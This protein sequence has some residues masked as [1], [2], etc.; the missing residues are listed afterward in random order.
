MVRAAR[1]SGD[2][3]LHIRVLAAEASAPRLVVQVD[4]TNLLQRVA[5]AR[6][7]TWVWVLTQPPP[8]ASAA[9]AAGPSGGSTN[10]ESVQRFVD[11]G[12]YQRPG[13]RRWL[14]A[15]LTSPGDVSVLPVPQLP[16]LP[17]SGEH[18]TVIEAA[19]P[20][21]VSADARKLVAGSEEDCAELWERIDRYLSFFDADGVEDAAIA[22][23]VW[24]CAAML[25][26]WLARHEDEIRGSS[27]LELGAGTGVCGLYAAAL[28][29]SRVL[30][31]DGAYVSEACRELCQ[32]NIDANR[33]LCDG[34]RIE[35]APLVWGDD[36]AVQA[37]V[38]TIQW[39]ILSDCIYNKNAQND[40]LCKSLACLLRPRRADGEC[41]PQPPRVVIAHEHRTRRGEVPWKV[42]LLERWDDGDDIMS[43]FNLAARRE[44]LQLMPVHSER[45]TAAHAGGFRWWSA[46]MTIFEVRA[47]C[48]W[49]GK[50]G[51]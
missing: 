3:H 24:P 17:S 21:V 45:P 22:Q 40:L 9:A 33:Q 18:I 26:R 29:A 4:A 41:V 20:P 34:A 31:T 8:P 7:T 44:Q 10:H 14:L 15:Q 6:G 49:N 43:A 5:D 51:D 32:H 36:A 19:H 2:R 35:L 30:L 11:G 37:L 28:G 27:V 46:D 38:G 16:P 39:V 25:C 50:S 48:S 1:R 13:L 47:D 42:E 23:E 12:P